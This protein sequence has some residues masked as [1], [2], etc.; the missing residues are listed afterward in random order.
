MRPD[1]LTP[2]LSRRWSPTIFDTQHE[3]TD[4][5]LGLLLAAAQWAPSAGNSQPWAFIVCRRGDLNHDRFTKYLSRGNAGWV[6][7]ASVVLVTL[8]QT[9][10]EPGEDA[11]S[12]SDYAEYDVGQAAAHITVQAV[13]LGLGVHQFAGFDHVAVTREFAIPEHYK[14]LTGMAIGKHA[15]P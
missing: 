3:V 14:V 15:S 6:P 2:L 12:Y 9:A 4:E 11:P 8:V 5:E 10:T 13:S 7:R 1:A